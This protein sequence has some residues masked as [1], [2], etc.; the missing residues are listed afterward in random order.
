MK[1]HWQAGLAAALCCSAALA[2]EVVVD[3]DAPV[4]N[5]DLTLAR[6]T[7]LRRAMA[8]A[9]EQEASFL[10]SSTLVSPTGN[11]TRT[12]LTP[13]GRAL[14]ARILSEHIERSRLRLTAEVTLEEPGKAATCGGQPLRKLVVTAFPLRY[15][16]QIGYGQFMGW[17]QMTGEELARLLNGRGKLLTAAMTERFPFPSAE[18]A[19]EVERKDGVPLVV[20]WAGQQRAQY[21]LAGIFRDFGVAKQAL[22]IPERQMTVDAYIFDGVSGDLVARREISR[23]LNFSWHIPKNLTPGA[24]SFSN[25]RLGETYYS[26]LDELVRWAEGSVDCLP[27][28]T[29]VIRV[30]SRKL[31]IDAGSDS[32]IEPG[33]ELVL[34]QLAPTV[35]AAGGDSLPGERSAIAGAV[36]RQVFPRYSVVEL[37]ARKNAPT[38]KVGD[39]LYGL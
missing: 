16:E 37:T 25:T 4:V 9:V 10:Q 39:V 31:F 36:V 22:V 21:V 19:P 33:H 14:S 38:V 6:Q 11:E 8:N 30:E 32:G 7:A 12:T 34:T 20:R 24:R 15:P 29:R 35:A 13:Q 18:V 2:V 23:A 3:A 26:L 1:L 27:F 5:D 17:P 28:S